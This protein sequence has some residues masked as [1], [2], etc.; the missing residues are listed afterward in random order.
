M[1]F[2]VIFIRK[3]IK[4][5]DQIKH[6]PHFH[7]KPIKHLLAQSLDNKETLNSIAS[8]SQGSL[9]LLKRGYVHSALSAVSLPKGVQSLIPWK[10]LIAQATWI[11]LGDIFKKVKLNQL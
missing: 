6:P 2:I 3:D 11:R 4:L 8:R 7:S 1:C 9:A 5:W 10:I